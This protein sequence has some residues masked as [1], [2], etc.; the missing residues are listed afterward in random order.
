MTAQS[1]LLGKRSSRQ[2]VITTNDEDWITLGRR[3]RD[4]KSVRY[5]YG[6]IS[7]KLKEQCEFLQVTMDLEAIS[8]V[9]DPDQ[10]S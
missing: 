8:E 4:Y 10:S 7:K 9:T 1:Q 3:R 6:R 2:M 5:E